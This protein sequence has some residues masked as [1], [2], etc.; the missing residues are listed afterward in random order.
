MGSSDHP[1]YP[2]PQRPR[3]LPP[4]GGGPAAPV[5]PCGTEVVMAAVFEVSV[6]L[7]TRVTTI[8]VGKVVV[9]QAD[10]K[11]IGIIPPPDDERVLACA[12]RRWIYEGVVLALAPAGSVQLHGI[13]R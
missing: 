13:R 8:P 3:V 4:T 10:G 5:D 9:L 7:G 2:K 11:R 1:V 6:S 12:S